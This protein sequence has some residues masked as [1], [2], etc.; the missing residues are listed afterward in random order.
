[1]HGMNQTQ[2]L[3]DQLFEQVLNKAIDAGLI[4]RDKDGMID[5]QLEQ[6]CRIVYLPVVQTIIVKIIRICLPQAPA[7]TRSADQGVLNGL[8]IP[9]LSGD[10][11]LYEFVTVWRFIICAWDVLTKGKTFVAPKSLFIDNV[12]Y[13]VEREEEKAALRIVRVTP[14]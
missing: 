1:M 13:T 8:D 12:W 10:T 11:G 14:Y 2:A 4:G 3:L 9:Q 7:A 6:A 5:A